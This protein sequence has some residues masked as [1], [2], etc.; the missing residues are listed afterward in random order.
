MFLYY[1]VLDIN[2]SNIDASIL[3]S[4]NNLGD[5]YNYKNIY[6]W[7]NGFTADYINNN[8]NNKDL[9]DLYNKAINYFGCLLF[10]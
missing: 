8:K 1:A 6:N 5:F 4:D 3:V 2:L 10:G 7:S 9:W